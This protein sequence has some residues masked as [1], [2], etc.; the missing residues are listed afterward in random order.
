MTLITMIYTTLCLI[1]SANKDVL[2]EKFLESEGCKRL[3]E[4]LYTNWTL[5]DKFYY[6]VN[7]DGD[8]EIVSACQFYSYPLLKSKSFNE[9]LKTYSLEVQH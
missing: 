9:L 5:Q 4:N 2:V 7:Y 8:S 1:R 3:E 6:T